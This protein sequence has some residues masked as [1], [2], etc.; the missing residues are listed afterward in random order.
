VHRSDIDDPAA[1][2]LLDHLPS[3]DLR[4]EEGALQIDRHDPVILLLGGVENAAA[5]LYAG[6]VDHDVDPAERRDR[7]IDKHLQ[8]GNPTRIGLDADRPVTQS[9]DLLLERVSRL[10]MAHIVDD[11]IGPQPG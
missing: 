11:N 10:R 7:L 2:T 9:G 3:R 4:A 8:V 1:A 6:I 5:S